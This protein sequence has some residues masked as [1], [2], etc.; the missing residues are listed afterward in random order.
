MKY[1][2][3]YWARNV[4]RCVQSILCIPALLYV[5]ACTYGPDNTLNLTTEEKQYLRSLKK[6]VIVAPCPDFPPIDFTDA[7]GNFVGLSQDY[8]SEIGKI[9]GISFKKVSPSTWADVLQAAKDRKVDIVLSIQDVPERH[10]YLR[11]TK[12]YVRI[13]NV[14]VTRKSYTKNLTLKDLKGLHVAAVKGYAVVDYITQQ[15]PKIQFDLVKNETEGLMKLSFGEYDAMIISLSTVSYLIDT[16]SITNLRIAGNVG[17]GWNL[18]FGVRNDDPM[19]YS[20]IS[21]ALNSIP[22]H[23]R[24][25]IYRKWISLAPKPVYYEKEFW[26]IVAFLITGGLFV[27]IGIVA[28]N[29][30]LRRQVKIK[31][32]QLEN[33]LYWHKKTQ[34]QLKLEKERLLITIQSIGDAFI[35]TDVDGTI[36]LSNKQADM[37]LGNKIL[38]GKLVDDLLI[39]IEP[40][41]QKQV[42]PI[43][44]SVKLKKTVIYHHL[45]CHNN[46]KIIDVSVVSSPVEVNEGLIGAVTIIRDITEMLSMQNELIKLQQFESLGILA[47]GIAHDFNNI[48]TAIIGNAEIAEQMLL[49]NKKPHDVTDILSGIKKSVKSAQSLTSQ[50]LTYAKGGK[51]IKKTG[52]IVQLIRDTVEFVTHGS[53]VK[54]EYEIEDSIENFDFDEHQLS[55]VFRNL[56]LN[57]VQAMG[58]GGLLTVLIKKT[59]FISED[60]NLPAG[61]YLMI[62]FTDTG[63]GIPEK[64]IN[65]IFDPY[66]TTKE[67]GTGLGLTT[68]LSIVKQHGGTITV[69][70]N[71]RGASFTIYLPL[72][73]TIK[74][75][76]IKSIDA[77]DSINAHVL[78]LDDRQEILEVTSGMLEVLGCTYD[79][80]THSDD[81]IGKIVK[82]KEGKPFDCVLVD[83]TIPG[84]ISGVDAF[85]QMKKIQENIKGIVMSG[86]AD[87][88]AIADFAKYGFAWYLVKPF[89]FD[90][91][92]QAL[93]KALYG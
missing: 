87:N 57:A 4:S 11:F 50:L 60:L 12:P 26:Y 75:D 54:V 34:E 38:L 43:N 36:I 81:A 1:R 83:V 13:P 64:N 56:A 18:C 19:L 58:N 84:S 66:F 65:K 80:A 62:Q 86:Y 9:T 73:N 93:V 20:V 35:S 71:T 46:S 25:D 10:S 74:S 21:K 8:L 63:G 51:P 59:E 5:I 92:K 27:I 2:L 15:Y 55:H 72:E 68:S 91:L 53:S 7:S 22:E 24:S 69:S 37:L 49:K 85:A 61:R 16:Y 3:Q 90:D 31:T 17:Y 45:Q 88:S 39:F 82:S 40:I 28:W 41:A 77:V 47:A 29:S 52:D 48:L 70:S 67:K 79:T 76:V 78:I 89:T 33:E 44:E 32:E 30:S 14:I 23:I 42:N 6:P